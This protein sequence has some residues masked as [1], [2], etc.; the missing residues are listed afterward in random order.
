MK[1]YVIKKLLS[2][3]LILLGASLIVF[4]AIRMLP[5]DPPPDGR[6]AGHPG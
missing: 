1:A 6:A 3:P 4:M 5:G 2:L